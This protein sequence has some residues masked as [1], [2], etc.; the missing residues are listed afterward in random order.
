MDKFAPHFHFWKTTCFQLQGA[1]AP[2][3]LTRGSV[4]GP[5]MELCTHHYRL[6]LCIHH[7]W[8]YSSCLL[9]SELPVLWM[10]SRLPIISQAKEIRL[11]Y[12]NQRGSP[13]G[14]RR[15]RLISKIAL[16]LC[17]VM[18]C[19]Y[20][21]CCVMLRTEQSELSQCMNECP[22]Y[23]SLFG[24]KPGILQWGLCGWRLGNGTHNFSFKYDVRICEFWCILTDS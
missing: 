22:S 4:S 12:L 9:C 17:Y 19:R 21:G 23:S 8:P 5:L 20:T 11:G 16:L 14:D 3:P 18:Y 15:Q 13:G 24:V 7:I 10:T 6:V 2:D 1:S